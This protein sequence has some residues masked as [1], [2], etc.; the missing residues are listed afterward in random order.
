LSIV[1][2]SIQTR[3]KVARSKICQFARLIAIVRAAD[4]KQAKILARSLAASFDP[5][6]LRDKGVHVGLGEA[7]DLGRE[8]DEG[9]AALPHQ[10]VNRPAADVQAPGDL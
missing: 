8:F 7:D 1:S 4:T 6:I 5:A 2:L 9:Q 3:I 10:V